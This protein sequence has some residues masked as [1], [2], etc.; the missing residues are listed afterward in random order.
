MTEFIAEIGGNHQ[1]NA[2][3][4]IKLTQDA[5]KSGVR[6]LKYQIYTGD[7]LVNAQYD[8]DREAHF[9]SFTLDGSVYR[10]VVDLCNEAN[11]EFMAS[12]WSE[13]LLNEFDPYVA[14]YKV[15]SGDLTNYPLIELMAKRG[16]PIILS[17]GLSEFDEVVSAVEFIRSINEVYLRAEMLAVLQCTSV[18]PCPLNEVN[19]RVIDSYREHFRSAVG[20]SHHTIQ[21]SPI[22]AAISMGVDVIEF[23]YTDT[24][25]DNTFRD[26]LISV[27]A[28]EYK[29]LIA[30][31]EE[32]KI[33]RG[34]GS[35][36]VTATE[37]RTEHVTS[38]RRSLFY[39]RDFP[40]GYRLKAD[41]VV[42]LRP[43]VGVC[44]S[45]IEK[46]LGIPLSLS[47]RTG[48]ALD[49]LHFQN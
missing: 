33:L 7:S 3:R 49:D 20:Y 37:H 4:L 19:L 40:Q 36:S 16:K 41:D 43:A 11:V 34:H 30:F 17:T 15:G 39:K 18:Y 32:T 12:I 2:E 14:R 21:Y 27:D 45:K 35:K 23:H 8:P 10:R 13:E 24:K 26:H 38:F 47:V 25:H 6:V 22:Y 44:P 29:K 31:A 1:G 48:E 5:I 46:Y 28:C 9:R 42:A